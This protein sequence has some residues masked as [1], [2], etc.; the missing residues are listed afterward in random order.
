MAHPISSTSL[1]VLQ[2]IYVEGTHAYITSGTLDSDIYSEVAEV[3]NR[4]GSKWV[5]GKTAAHIFPYCPSGAIASVIESGEMPPKNPRAF[6]PTPP[7]LIDELLDNKTCDF[8]L[9]NIANGEIEGRVL[10]PSAGVGGVITHLLEKYPGLRGKIDAVEI[11]PLKVGVLR[12][13]EAGQVFQG[14][15]MEFIPTEKYAVVIM[16]PPFS[17][18]GNRTLYIN[19][20][21]RAVDMVRMSNG[22]GYIG[23]IAPTSF[24]HN[25]TKQEIDFRN[26]V[27]SCANWT[28][29]G[30]GLFKDVGTGIDTATIQFDIEN[31]DW[32]G[33]PYG[34]YDSWHAWLFFLTV[35]NSQKLLSQVELVKCE[36]DL[37]RLLEQVNKELC[38]EGNGI[39]SHPLFLKQIFDE[40]K[41]RQAE[42]TAACVDEEISERPYIEN[43]KEKFKAGQMALF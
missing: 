8:Y 41:A 5:G 30:K 1:A 25:S 24:L 35:D 34:E 28:L 31:K 3:L 21:Q 36:N 37:V 32:R 11:D 7:E 18:A 38:A 2:Q 22:S 10:E 20:I 43:R 39:S 40:I 4:L 23:T 42:A 13:L 6:F 14:D 26:L 9:R 16:N 12:S 19:H 29:N 17:F 33:L 15:F 27:Y